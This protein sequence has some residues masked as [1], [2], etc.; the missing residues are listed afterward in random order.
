MAHGYLSESAQRKL[1]NEHQHDR[2]QMVF[3]KNLHPC[4]LDEKIASVSEVLSH[5]LF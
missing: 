2:V 4:S 5:N 1:S 3:E